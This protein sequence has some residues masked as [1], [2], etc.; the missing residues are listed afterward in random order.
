MIGLGLHVETLR[1]GTSRRLFEEGGREKGS[2]G[3][4]WKYA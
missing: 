1:M 4:A 2:R 3:V